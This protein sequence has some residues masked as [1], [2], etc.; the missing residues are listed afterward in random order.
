M[1]D[2]ALL[3]LN[4]KLD[5]LTTQV[6]FLSEEARQQQRRRQEWDELKNDL[7]PVASDMYR[8][9]VDQLDEV[10][11]YVQLEDG[12]RLLKRLMRNTRNLEQMLDQ[13][14]GMMALWQDLNPLT[15]DAFLALMNRLDEM[16]RK[17]YFTFLR[18]GMSIMDEIVTSFS[19][20]D[21]EQLGQNV[22]LILNT[23]KEMTQPEIMMLMQNTAHVMLEEE[24]MKDVSMMSILRQLND[25]AVKRGLAKTL[26]VLKTV[27]EN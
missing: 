5:L 7:T 27:S 4:E 19:E 15:Q 18:G 17:G 14:E 11:S 25:P 12:L 10:E 22:V 26:T 2:Q 6:A 23:V 3:E 20:E 21:V 8:L 1:D 24:P 16:E 9:A 13:M